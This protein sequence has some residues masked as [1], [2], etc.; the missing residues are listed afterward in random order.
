MQALPERARRWTI[1]TVGSAPLEGYIDDISYI[2]DPNDHTAKVKGHIDNKEGRLL[3]GKMISAKVELPPPSDVVEV[4]TDAVVDDGQQ[5]IVFVQ[6]NA[7]KQYY[8]MRRV[9]LVGR[10][11]QTLFVRNKPFTKTEERTAEEEEL[12]MLPKRP[13]APG[14][15]ILRTGVGELKTALLDKESQPRQKSKPST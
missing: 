13:L 12:G 7:E 4:P 11:D 15:A 2:I 5:A 1:T 10:F 6:T 9:E 3:A 8:T 14:E